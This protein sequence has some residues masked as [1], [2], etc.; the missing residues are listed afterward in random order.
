MALWSMFGHFSELRLDLVPT[1]P[2]CTARACQSV[3]FLELR[4]CNHHACSWVPSWE[5]GR[6]DRERPEQKGLVV[7]RAVLLSVVAVAVFF[8]LVF[9][10]NGDNKNNSEGDQVRKFEATSIRVKGKSATMYQ[11]KNYLVT[12]ASGPVGS[13]G[14]PEIIQVGDVVTVKDSTIRVEHIV[15]TEFLKDMKYG[16]DVLGKKGDIHCTIVQSLDNLPN[17]DEHDQRDRLWI[18]VKD[19]EPLEGKGQ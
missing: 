16:K 10:N 3:Q 5:V 7:S 17:V 19:C 12:L 9:M 8:A 15:V 13:E 4:G 18:N 11:H 2:R 14:I 1:W 6:R